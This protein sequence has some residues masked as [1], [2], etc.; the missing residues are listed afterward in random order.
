MEIN[1]IEQLRELFADVKVIS[2]ED[3]L[4]EIFK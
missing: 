4:R 3:E 2:N 1:D